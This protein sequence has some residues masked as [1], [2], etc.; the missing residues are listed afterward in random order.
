[1]AVTTGIKGI[2]PKPTGYRHVLRTMRK[3]WTAYLFLFPSLLQ[4]AVLMVF[5]RRLF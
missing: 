4:F 2:K 5:P 1:M 3:E